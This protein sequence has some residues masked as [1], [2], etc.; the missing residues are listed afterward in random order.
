V[1]FHLIRHG[2]YPLLDHALGGRDDHVL[3]SDGERQAE[4]LAASLHTRAI[5][6]VLASPVL[7]ARQTA[8]PLADRLN[9]QVHADPAFTEIDFAS[10]TNRRFDDLAA[11]PAWHAWNNFRATASVPGGESMLQVQARAISGLRHL[12]GARGPEIAIITH[13]DVIKAIVVHILGAPLDLMHRLLIDPASI[14]QVVLES[15]GAQVVML[16]GT[17]PR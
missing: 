6:S 3:S 5:T 7:R 10:W 1:L 11:D 13:A 14:T 2:H 4:R 9:L 12:V 16:N 8:Q 15:D 17:N